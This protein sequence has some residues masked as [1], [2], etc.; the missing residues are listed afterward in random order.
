[1]TEDNEHEKGSHTSSPSF[2]DNV[3]VPPEQPSLPGDEAI[4]VNEVSPSFANSVVEGQSPLSPEA[5]EIS[6]T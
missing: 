4:E 2:S 3:A 5:D 1:M 6:V